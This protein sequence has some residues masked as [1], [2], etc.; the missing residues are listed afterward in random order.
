MTLG[1]LVA[2]SWTKLVQTHLGE[3]A[4]YTEGLLIARARQVVLAR[5]TGIVIGLTGWLV[6]ANA[7]PSVETGVETG[8]ES[9]VGVSSGAEAT[10]TD[11][12]II[13]ASIIVAA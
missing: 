9:C 4:L 5:R 7:E 6:Q 2:A 3:V 11:L 13:T 12:W 10:S 1:V 8:R